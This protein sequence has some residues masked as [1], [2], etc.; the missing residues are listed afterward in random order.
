[1]PGRAFRIQPNRHIRRYQQDGQVDPSFGQAGDTWISPGP[2]GSTNATTIA[3]Q[4]NKIVVAG[5][6]SDQYFYNQGVQSDVAVWRFTD[7][8][9]LDRSFGNSGKLIRDNFAAVDRDPLLS[10][11]P[12]GRLSVVLFDPAAS[13]GPQIAVLRHAAGSVQPE[14]SLN[15]IPN[16]HRLLDT[17]SGIGAPIGKVETNATLPL[18]VTGRA[19]VPANAVAVALNVT[20]TGPEGPGFVTV[21]PCGQPVPT[22]SNLNFVPG[23]TIPNA[24]IVRIG[25]DG[26]VCIYAS[27]RM[28]LIA[29]VMGWYGPGTD[30]RPLDVPTRK[31]DTRSGL[32]IPGKPTDKIG[33]ACLAVLNPDDL[34]NTNFLNEVV[35]N[36]TVTDPQSAGFMTVY[37][38]GQPLPTASNLNFSADQTIANLGM[39]RTNH[40]QPNQYPTGAVCFYSTSPTHLIVDVLAT[41]DLGSAHRPL[42]SPARLLDT[43]SGIGAPASKVGVGDVLVLPVT[44]QVG[45]PSNAT[46]VALNVTV[47]APDDA[48]FV[49]VYPCGQDLP[50]ASNL[51]FTAGQTIPNLVIAR[52]GQNGSICFATSART[53]LIADIAEW[54]PAVS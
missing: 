17:R 23:Q 38:C 19:G 53:H 18:T 41:I 44:G 35:L 6:V 5:E 13:T 46:A 3:M 2:V 42:A 25:K 11:L 8:G 24:V 54:Y 40:P 15:T 20:V 22:A 49:T 45:I 26:Q 29:D 32:G 36:V 27:A 10:V 12:N 43:R 21:F 14:A 4:G 16:P 9:Q 30:L 37:Q 47:T 28:H 50:N 1:L 39:A 31:I 51:N 34:P 7:G 48:G 52:V 33:G